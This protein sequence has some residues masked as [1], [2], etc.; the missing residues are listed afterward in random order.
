VVQNIYL[1]ALIG[2]GLSLGVLVAAWAAMALWTYLLTTGLRPQVSAAEALPQTERAAVPIPR[3]I[4]APMPGQV[5]TLLVQ[6]GDTVVF[7]QELCLIA[8]G[9]RKTAVRAGFVGRVHAVLIEADQPV[10]R[11]QVL[12]EI[13]AG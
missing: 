11:N 5:V 6:P 4:T 7:G 3:R 1:I 10:S 9:E 8:S 13:L 12:F 2:L